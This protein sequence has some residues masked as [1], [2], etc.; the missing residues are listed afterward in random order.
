MAFDAFYKNE[1]A[2][3]EKSQS[4][5]ELFENL[6]KPEAGWAKHNPDAALAYI[7]VTHLDDGMVDEI[8]AAA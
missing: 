4:T 7:Y 1:A 6:E 3:V 5:T 2:E 8:L